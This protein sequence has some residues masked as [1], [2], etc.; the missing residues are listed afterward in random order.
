MV[1]GCRTWCSVFSVDSHNSHS[2]LVWHGPVWICMFRTQIDT[3]NR[4]L[5]AKLVNSAQQKKYSHLNGKKLY[6]TDFSRDIQARV[7]VCVWG[8]K[9]KMSCNIKMVLYYTF[10]VDWCW[11]RTHTRIHK[12]ANNI[13]FYFLQRLLLFFYS[14]KGIVFLM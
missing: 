2:I 13:H 4:R 14:M 9:I 12:Y 3:Q 11:S 7:Y 8:N 6:E 5:F 10:P 1:N